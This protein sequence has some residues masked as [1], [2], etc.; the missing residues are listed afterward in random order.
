MPIRWSKMN[1]RYL[2][3]NCMFYIRRNDQYGVGALSSSL[4][5]SPEM[6]PETT[7]MG[8]DHCNGRLT[9]L[10]SAG[11]V[12]LDEQRPLFEVRSDQTNEIFCQFCS[13]H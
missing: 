6:P 9:P 3:Q 13:R 4:E 11:S 1:C 12:R 8:R 2:L 5:E 10:P 7:Y